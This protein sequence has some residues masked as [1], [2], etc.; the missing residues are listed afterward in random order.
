VLLNRL[1]GLIALQNGCFLP[2][3]IERRDALNVILRTR[4]LL[5]VSSPPVKVA[6]VVRME[7]GE[8][9][10]GNEI[11]VSKPDRVFRR[12]L[13]AAVKSDLVSFEDLF[14]TCAKTA[15]KLCKGKKVVG[16]RVQI[17]STRRS[18]YPVDVEVLQRL[19]E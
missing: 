10:D 18:M 5:C 19:L 4:K 16:K 13:A 3:A 8:E 9:K 7:E 15:I 12:V 1:A 6:R 17:G 11:D 2:G 14:G